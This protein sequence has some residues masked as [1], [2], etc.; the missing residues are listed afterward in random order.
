V[1][2]TLDIIA[3]TPAIQGLRDGRGE[4]LD[5]ALAAVK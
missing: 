5:A 4:V 1:G 3:V 2:I